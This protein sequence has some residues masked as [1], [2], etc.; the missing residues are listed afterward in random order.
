M[1]VTFL[2]VALILIATSVLAFV[3]I[4]P[5]PS[6]GIL[7]QRVMVIGCVTGDFPDHPWAGT[8]IRLGSEESILTEDGSFRFAV[9]P[10]T[11]ILTVCCSARFQRIY[12]EIRVTDRDLDVPLSA[13]PLK[14]IPGR[15]VVRGG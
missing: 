12:E 14:E 2:V 5:T 10:G 15:L 7:S 8:V 4:G 9:L 3:W 6:P 11:H 1:R 13:R